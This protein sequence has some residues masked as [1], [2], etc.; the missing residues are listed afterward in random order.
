MPEVQRS[1]GEDLGLFMKSKK[2][3]M[4]TP[5]PSPTPQSIYCV[6][7]DRWHT[8]AVHTHTDS[9]LIR[10]AI[11]GI[12]FFFFWPCYKAFGFLGPQP[13]LLAVKAQSPSHWP[14]REF[15]L[16]PL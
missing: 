14:T 7:K 11:I 10:D 3:D 9:K 13:G 4:P 1:H 6:F 12:I 2:E 15:P 5:I 16:S 8:Y